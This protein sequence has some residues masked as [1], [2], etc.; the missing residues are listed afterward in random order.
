MIMLMISVPYAPR[1]VVWYRFLA[2]SLFF[3][4]RVV[5]EEIDQYGVDFGIWVRPQ[6][7]SP[8]KFYTPDTAG[9]RYAHK[10]L[11]VL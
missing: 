2:G 8:Q 5:Q 7:F 1:P 9:F 4:H 6:D 10:R 3:L 11:A